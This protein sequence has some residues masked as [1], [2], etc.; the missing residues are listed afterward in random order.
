MDRRAR[1]QYAAHNPN[2]ILSTGPKEKFT[3]RLVIGGKFNPPM[4]KD[5]LAARIGGAGFGGRCGRLDGLG[6]V[7]GGERSYSGGRRAQSD[8]GLGR[9]RRG[10][11]QQQQLYNT[12]GVNR[13]GGRPGGFGGPGIITKGVKK[14]LGNVS[15]A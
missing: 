12:G 8:G 6:T 5:F 10:N 13:L 14:I 11:E 9:E 7:F 4:G 15:T 1:A 3:S 2:S